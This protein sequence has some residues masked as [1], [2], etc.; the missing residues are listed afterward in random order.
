[1][2]APDWPK[3]FRPKKKRRP[4]GYHLH[5]KAHWVTEAAALPM[6]AVLPSGNYKQGMCQSC[7][8]GTRACCIKQ[9]DV[10]LRIEVLFAV[11]AFAP[12]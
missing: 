5:L 7:A 3:N 1:M 10:Q 4:S 9:L 2:Y 6:R 12:G 11:P 8:S